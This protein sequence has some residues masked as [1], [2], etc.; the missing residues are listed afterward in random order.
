MGLSCAI[1]H[2]E[3]LAAAVAVDPSSWETR[4]NCHGL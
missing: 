3:G 2:I 1:E 4:A